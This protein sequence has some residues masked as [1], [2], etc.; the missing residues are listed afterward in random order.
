M[1][2]VTTLRLALAGGRTDRS[3]IILTALGAALGTLALL[4]AATVLAVTAPHAAA[5]T[6]DLLNDE[7]LRPGVAFGMLLLTVPVLSFVAQCSRLGA[8]GRERRLA[9][10]RMVGATPR[11]V[12]RIAAAETAIASAVGSL[13]GLCVYFVGRAL[14]DAPGPDGRRP[15]PTDVLPHPAAMAGITVGAPLLVTLMTVLA[16]RRVTLTPL[17]VVRGT[18]RGRPSA[19]PGVLILVGLGACALVEP[20]HRYFTEH[21]R[22]DDVPTL[23]MA[24][25]IVSGLLVVSIGVVSGTG[26]IAHTTGRLLHRFARRPAGL[27]AGRR[28]MADP[29]SGSRTFSAMLVALIAGS[30]AAGLSALTVAT[31]EAQE[32]N[33]RR[34]ARLLGEPYNPPG[35]TFYERAY[36]LI[37]Y[38]VVVAAAI[39][40]TGLLVALVDGVTARRRTLASLVAAGTPRGILSRALGWQVLTPIVPIVLL[41]V[42]VGALLPRLAVPDTRDSARMEVRRC[43]PLPGDPANACQDDAY[44]KAHTVLLTAEKVPVTVHVPWHQLLLLAGGA[45]AATVA[46]TLVSL[47]FLRMNVRA[48]ELRVR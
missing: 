33:T 21:P 39:A 23:V 6:N 34:Y 28:L 48:A 11:Q 19:T 8:P 16:L 1:S 24:A 42:A 18:R 30:A 31:V 43:I 25:L 32:E 40:V 14:F 10:M 2:P 9:A 38:A 13:T 47:A 15:L 5:Y 7:G 41:S 22:N 35:S 44:E 12:V 17:G 37:G 26:W 29:W 45:V 46:I 20:A 4:A 36:E 3:R 27:L